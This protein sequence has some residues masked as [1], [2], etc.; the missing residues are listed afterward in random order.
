VARKAR[1][2]IVNTPFG[3][4][5][6]KLTLDDLRRFLGD[7]PDESLTWEAKGRDVRPGTNS[8]ACA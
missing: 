7:G 3:V 5:W 1:I 8:C 6:E 2:T 4:P